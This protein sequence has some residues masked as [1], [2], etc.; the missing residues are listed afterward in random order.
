MLVEIEYFL[1][2]QFFCWTVAKKK[3]KAYGW[4]KTKKITTLLPHG[5]YFNMKFVTVLYIKMFFLLFYIAN[6]LELKY[7]S[8]NYNLIFLLILDW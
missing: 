4:F 1:H 8:T 7:T 3:K 2:I 6:F 5:I